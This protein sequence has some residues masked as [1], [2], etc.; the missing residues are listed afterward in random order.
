MFQKF[1]SFHIFSGFH[2]LELDVDS[3]VM[4]FVV[5]CPNNL[6]VLYQ[7]DL[8]GSNV[9]S[10]ASSSNNY[11]SWTEISLDKETGYVHDFLEV[12]TVCF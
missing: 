4:Y 1:V 10:I 3:R 9:E 6:R 7:A 8:D 5:T 2:T 12:T 11:Q